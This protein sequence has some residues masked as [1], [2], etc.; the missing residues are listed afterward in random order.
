LKLQCEQIEAQK[1]EQ[2]LNNQLE[3]LKKEYASN[4]TEKENELKKLKEDLMKKIAELEKTKKL[5]ESEKA[6][7]DKQAVDLKKT[8]DQ[9][10]KDKDA[11]EGLSKQSQT[12]KVYC[13]NQKCPLV[14][15]PL[16]KTL[17]YGQKINVGFLCRIKKLQ[18]WK[19]T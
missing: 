6:K 1:K 4:L 13:C 5:M 9:L 17:I 18:S 8:L 12:E 2:E 15:S 11:Q 14:A 10:Q 7:L 19:K 16:V 3:I